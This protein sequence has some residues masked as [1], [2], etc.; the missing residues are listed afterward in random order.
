GIGRYH[1]DEGLLSFMNPKAI[2]VDRGKADY[3][4]IWFP[5]KDKL[6]HALNVFRGVASKKLTSVIKGFLGMRKVAADAHKP[7]GDK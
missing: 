1:G 3:D 7:D 4:P 2:L 5:H 6:G